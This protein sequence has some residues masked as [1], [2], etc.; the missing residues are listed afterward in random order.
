MFG[1][2]SICLV[3]GYLGW[4]DM[5]GSTSCRLSHEGAMKVCFAVWRDF[6]IV[7]VFVYFFLVC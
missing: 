5:F 4:K 3:L 7:D 1:P 2:Y 6:D